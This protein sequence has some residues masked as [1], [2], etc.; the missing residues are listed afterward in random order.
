MKNTIISLNQVKKNQTFLV[1]GKAYNLSRL[2][3]SRLNIPYMHILTTLAFDAFL[4]QNSLVILHKALTLEIPL[5]DKIFIAT[6][7]KRKIHKGKMPQLIQNALHK[8]IKNVR[9]H[10]MSIR[11]SA[12]IEDGKYNSFAGQFDSFLNIGQKDLIKNIRKC[13]A[14]L[15]TL[16]SIIYTHKKGIALNSVKMGVMIQEMIHGSTFGN[17]FTENVISNNTNQS[18]I[19]TAS[20]EGDEVTSGIQIPDSFVVNKHTYNVDAKQVGKKSAFSELYI[21]K[22]MQIATKIERVFK[23]PQEIEWAIKNR[24][25]YIL[26]SRPLTIR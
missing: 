12:T 15:F 10:K 8:K 21:P 9:F 20:G 26:Q 23:R 19:E 16:R 7:L 6:D 25:I 14:S 24:T 22:L 18:V 5:R 13:W 1:G 3:Q 17:I 2:L 11:S 4:E